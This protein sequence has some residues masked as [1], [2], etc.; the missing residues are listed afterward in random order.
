MFAQG[1]LLIER[2]S[3]VAPS[4]TLVQTGVPLVLLEGEATGHCHAI[5][6]G[7]TLFR[8][9]DL[10]RDIPAGLYLGHLQIAAAYARVTHEEHAPLTLPRGT[11]RVRR[12][13]ELG[14]RDARVL[15]D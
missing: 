13:R 7:A 12:Q 11:Y 14:P 1:D 15:A 9:D 6:E 10:A 4:G 8:D 5:R 2:V 3:D